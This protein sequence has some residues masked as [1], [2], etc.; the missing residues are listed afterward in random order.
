MKNFLISILTILINLAM[1][2]LFF[3]KLFTD[4][5]YLV[6]IDSTN[7]A[8][9]VIALQH[10]NM[11]ENLETL[12][13]LY[14]VPVAIL[15]IVLSIVLATLS[16]VIKDNQKLRIV[17]HIVLIISVVTFLLLLWFAAFPNR[18]VI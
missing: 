9:A 2:P 7:K 5:G 6:G 12:D 17:S 11:I 13:M 16:I 3:I 15:V 1:I 8:T 18:I 10:Y 14:A 4:M